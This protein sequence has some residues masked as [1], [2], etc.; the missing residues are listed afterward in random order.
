MV[1]QSPDV[2]PNKGAPRVALGCPR[3]PLVAGGQGGVG[4]NAHSPS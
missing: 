3:V 4:I 1:P 2:E